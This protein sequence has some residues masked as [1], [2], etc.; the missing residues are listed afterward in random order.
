MLDR[1]RLDKWGFEPGLANTFAEI[2]YDQVGPA[3]FGQLVADSGTGG[4][5]PI[6]LAGLVVAV[7]RLQAAVGVQIEAKGPELIILGEQLFNRGSAGR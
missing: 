3:L 6:G 5:D 1:L 7:N 2:D 4:F